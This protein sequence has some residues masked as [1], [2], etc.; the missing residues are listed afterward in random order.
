MPPDSCLLPAVS[1]SCT[2]APGGFEPPFSDPKSDVLP[3]DEGAVK[4]LGRDNW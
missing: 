1:S 4:G 2:I 3:L